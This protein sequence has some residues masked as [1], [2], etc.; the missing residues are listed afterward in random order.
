LQVAAAGLDAAGRL[1]LQ[2]LALERFRRTAMDVIFVRHGSAQDRSE[3]ADDAQ[4]Q[5]T[6]KGRTEVTT[7]AHALRELGVKL[8]A[9][10]TS[11]AVR[12]VQTGEILADVHDAARVE[13]A[14]ML[15]HPAD[16]QAVRGRLQ[17]LLAEGVE[18]V[19]L[20]GHAPSLDH[21]IGEL[22]AA[23]PKIGVSL[24]KAGAACV[25]LP[26]DYPNAAPELRWVM[27][28]EVLAKLAGN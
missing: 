25:E 22:A 17:Q 20:V 11:P 3:V 14:Q 9:V 28:R 5:L 6:D 7:T 2:C 26:A 13:T 1:A 15:A 24:S 23:Q 10:L 19:A 16:P 27:R 8:A 18:C 12:A 4:R 21:C